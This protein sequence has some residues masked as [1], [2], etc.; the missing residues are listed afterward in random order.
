MLNPA[1]LASRQ[2]QHENYTNRIS[3]KKQCQYDYRA[4]NGE[5]FSTVT[6]TLEAART[7]R[8]QWLQ[9]KGLED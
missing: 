7:K 4:S 1:N 3:K 9:K 5:L 8:D 6:L 2:E